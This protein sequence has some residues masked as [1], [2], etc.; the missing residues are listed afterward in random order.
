MGTPSCNPPS[1]ALIE[2]NSGIAGLGVIIGFIVTAW[3][4][5]VVAMA[6]AH[7]DMKRRRF[8]EISQFLEEFT[9]RL[10][11]S[12]C[13]IQLTTGTAIVIAALTQ[14]RTIS[15]YH[16]QIVLNSWSLTLY[17]FRSARKAYSQ[18][19]S[20]SLPVLVRVAAIVINCILSLVLQSIIFIK[21]TKD[22]DPSNGNKCYRIGDHS[23]FGG[24]IFWISG[25][26]LFTLTQ[27][28]CFIPHAG[29][30]I[31]ELFSSMRDGLYHNNKKWWNEAKEWMEAKEWNGSKSW[32]QGIFKVVKLVLSALLRTFGWVLMEILVFLTHCQ[33]FYAFE[34]LAFVTISVWSTADIIDLKVKNAELLSGSET[35]W[36]FG[37]VLAITLLGMPI[38]TTID[39]M[40]DN[41]CY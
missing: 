23:G 27:L 12:L 20:T 38:F 2:P 36:E 14:I 21:E 5:F 19:R 33:G 25:L 18:D 16:Q 35:T 3:Y 41:D 4:T 17:S 39:A 40:K 13:D 9:R 6:V 8:R 28:L 31:S 15:Y 30:R 24:A 26:S 34:V 32:I 11:D 10:L 7:C 1:N 22:W 29:R 37:Q